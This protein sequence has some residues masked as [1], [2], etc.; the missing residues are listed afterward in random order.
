M[1]LHS[2]VARENLPAADRLIRQISGAFDILAKNP[3]LGIRQDEIRLGLRCKPVRRHYLIFYEVAGNA[4]R[5]L[6]VVHGAR[7]LND[8]V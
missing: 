8:L 2:Y 6:R 3:E 7:E 4:L 1:A 5:I